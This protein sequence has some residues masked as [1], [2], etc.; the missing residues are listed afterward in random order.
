MKVEYIDWLNPDIR[1][2]S[3]IQVKPDSFDGVLEAKIEAFSDT[4][5]IWD[6]LRWNG[7]LYQDTT[8]DGWYNGV[9]NETIPVNINEVDGYHT[10]DIYIPYGVVKLTFGNGDIYEIEKS[11]KT[12]VEINSGSGWWNHIILR[13]DNIW[14]FEG[15][16]KLK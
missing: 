4:V 15:F 10:I 6:G 7:A 14:N 2:N 5:L 16:T 3:N 11:T 8:R 9:Y 13:K 12:W 1:I